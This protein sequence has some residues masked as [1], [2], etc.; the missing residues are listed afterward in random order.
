MTGGLSPCQVFWQAAWIIPRLIPVSR[1]ICLTDSPF[2][3]SN[4]KAAFLLTR[5]IDG[6]CVPLVKCR[7][8]HIIS[9]AMVSEILCLSSASRYLLS[10]GS[11]LNCKKLSLPP[12]SSIIGRVLVSL[13]RP[14]YSC[15]LLQGYSSRG[16]IPALGGLLWMYLTM[17]RRYSSVS[18]I[19]LVYRF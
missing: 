16:H 8:L 3:F 17:A 2:V 11:L 5:F 19:W 6:I 4:R 10:S 13:L 9:L 1:S 12:T 14:I 18:T 15:Q 7:V